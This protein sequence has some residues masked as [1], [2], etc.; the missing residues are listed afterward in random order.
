MFFTL[1]NIA[2]G[3]QQKKT[4]WTWIR[5]PREIIVIGPWA[6]D[7]AVYPG[8]QGIPPGWT[9]FSLDSTSR[10][11]RIRGNCGFEICLEWSYLC[12]CNKCIYIYNYII[13]IMSYID[14]SLYIYTYIYNYTVH[15]SMTLHWATFIRWLLEPKYTSPDTYLVAVYL[16]MPTAYILPGEHPP[17]MQLRP[18]RE[19]WDVAGETLRSRRLAEDRT[20]LCKATA[21]CCTYWD[22]DSHPGEDR[23]WTVQR[24]SHFKSF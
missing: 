17:W 21:E 11:S 16:E 14:I 7:Y 22:N 18:Q 8:S 1:Q 19:V 13:Y 23:I 20:V 12:L 6:V 9:V 15:I 24:Y 3:I 10:M 5:K 4:W 2:G